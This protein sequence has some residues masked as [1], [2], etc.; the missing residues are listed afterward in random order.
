MSR[1]QRLMRRQRLPASWQA[2][3]GIFMASPAGSGWR[4]RCSL[5]AARRTYVAPQINCSCVESAHCSAGAEI[6]P[7]IVSRHQDASELSSHLFTGAG[8]LP[9]E[10][11]GCS[12]QALG[13]VL[14][15]FRHGL[16]G[17]TRHTQPNC[18][19]QTVPFRLQGTRRSKV[20]SHNSL[21]RTKAAYE[22]LHRSFAAPSPC[23]LKVY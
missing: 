7:V 18:K 5:S 17:G 14:R 20:V 21:L 10:R 8:T 19:Q 15:A 13:V 1:L 9:W 12:T 6:C 3:V 22:C 4:F 23:A 2:E 11:V 16:P